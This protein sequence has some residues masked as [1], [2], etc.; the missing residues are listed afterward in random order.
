MILQNTVHVD[1]FG[2][3]LRQ[4]D[5]HAGINVKAFNV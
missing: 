1:T 4:Y 3:T 2:D 5:G